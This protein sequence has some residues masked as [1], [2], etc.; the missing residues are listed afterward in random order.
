MHLRRC[1]LHVSRQSPVH[2]LR[3]VSPAVVLLVVGHA[4]YASQLSSVPKEAREVI[5]QVDKAAQANHYAALRSL[6]A[7]EFSW[8]FGG[9]L[10]ADQA[11]AAWRED[12]HY[13]TEL[14]AVLK[15]GCYKSAPKKISC[16]G[17]GGFSFRAGFLTTPAGWRMEYF[18]EGD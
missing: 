12:K 10:D 3:S 5:A 11:I 18:V 9:D 6:M 7:D 14:H 8:S 1:I 4:A 16:P 13:L 15:L 2:T 17:K